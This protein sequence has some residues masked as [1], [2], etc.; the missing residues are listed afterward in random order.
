[1][2]YE[3]DHFAKVSES[4]VISKEHVQQAIDASE[5]RLDQ[6]KQ[7]MHENILRDIH[8]IET[9]NEK[10]A[11]INGLSVYQLGEY[12]FGRP[13]RI[14]AQARLGRGKVL[15][16]EREVK[17]GGN[18]HSKAVMILSSF[19][20]N[21]YARNRPLPISA[22]LVFEQSYGGVEGDS[23]SIAELSALI[24]AISRIPIKQSLAVT[25]SINQHGV[26]QAIGGVNQKIEGFFDICFSRGLTGSQGVIIPQSNVQHLMLEKRVINAVETGLFNIYAIANIDE[27][28]SLLMG[29][30]VGIKDQQGEYP[31]DTINGVVSSQIEEWINL[32]KTFTNPPNNE[33][34]DD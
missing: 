9:D 10:V 19:L 23:A 32:N 6:F 4:N 33:H 27:A 1:L 29:I 11:Q 5:K 13:T 2:L 25:G 15:D 16:I 21:R 8:L 28:L 22:S 31:A 12:T 7:R 34:T 24:S 20:A 26:V 18:L 17:L 3:S 30:P 14:T